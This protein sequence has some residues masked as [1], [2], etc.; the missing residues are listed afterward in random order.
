MAVTENYKSRQMHITKE[1][2]TITQIF[3]CIGNDLQFAGTNGLPLIGTPWDLYRSDLR[4]SDIRIIWKDNINA[5]V[6]ALFSSDGRWHKENQPDKISSI[7][8]TFDFVVEE[9]EIESYKNWVDGGEPKDWAAEYAAEYNSQNGADPT[10]TPKLSKYYTNIT[11]TERMNVPHWSW[12]AIRNIVGR[13]NSSD[14]L[15]QMK[16]QY[17]NRD[18][19]YDVT[20]DDTGNW[21]CAGVHV[22]TVGDENAEVT[23]T[24]LYKEQPDGTN[25]GWQNE[26]NGN[27]KITTNMYE[28]AN[29]FQR[30]LP[31]SNDNTSDD[32]LR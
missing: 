23:I 16:L 24:Y 14:F 9:K 1:G 29:F 28:A 20:G 8:N 5:T 27:V 7:R 12:D 22:E 21:L 26:V 18:I 4:C 2:T 6:E 3:D 25:A 31:T 17:P 13:V 15:R 30:T 11:F 10:T 19:E 32:A